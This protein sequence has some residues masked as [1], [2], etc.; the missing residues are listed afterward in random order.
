MVHGALTIKDIYKQCQ[1]EI[2]KGNGDHVVLLS[3]DD[4][5]N[6]FHYCWYAFTPIDKYT[7][8]FIDEEIAPKDKSII[9]G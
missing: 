3:S 6:E 5:G 7:E 1:E 8:E 9:L 4:E 2:K